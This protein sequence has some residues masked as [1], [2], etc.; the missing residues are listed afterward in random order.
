MRSILRTFIAVVGLLVVA[1]TTS[2][3]DIDQM[4]Q[5]QIQYLSGL[6]G[7]PYIAQRNA[8]LENAAPLPEYNASLSDHDPRYRA[9]YL[10]LQGWQNNAEFYNQIDAELAEVPAERLSKMAAGLQ[11][12][13][14]THMRRSRDE[15]HYAALPYAWEDILKLQG[16]KPDWMITN[17]FFII[18]GYPHEDSIDPLLIDMHLKDERA[19]A[20]HAAWLREMPKAALQDRLEED[21]NFYQFV[22]PQL[23]AALRGR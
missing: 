12:V 1:C 2:A 21:G 23:I 7:E 8:F 15:W 13:W 3:E 9:Q 5:E 18:R 10:I 4:T 22:R 14:N 6:S 20:T 17:S 16:T 19:A 11:T